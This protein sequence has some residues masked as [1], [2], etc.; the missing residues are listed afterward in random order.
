[1]AG[2]G[3]I[4]PLAVLV[5]ITCRLSSVAEC[6]A[7]NA[8]SGRGPPLADAGGGQAVRLFKTIAVSGA[9][10][11]DGVPEAIDIGIAASGGSVLVLAAKLARCVGGGRTVVAAHSLSRASL[12]QRHLRHGSSA[13]GV[14]GGARTSALQGGNIPHAVG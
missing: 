11:V 6:A 8:L 13:E 5:G 4:L 14:D 2:A 1:M 9:A 12:A 7:T 10:L 3:G